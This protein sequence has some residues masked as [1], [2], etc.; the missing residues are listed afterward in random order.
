VP[1]ELDRLLK[2][3]EPGGI[4]KVVWGTEARPLPL[5]IAGYLSRELPPLAQSLALPLASLSCI[6]ISRK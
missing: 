4:Q 5:R 3:H 6:R 2:G 1:S